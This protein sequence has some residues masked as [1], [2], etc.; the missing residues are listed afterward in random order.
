MGLIVGNSAAKDILH[1]LLAF[2]H[3]DPL[4]W[5]RYIVRRGYRVDL[6]TTRPLGFI[7]KQ[8]HKSTWLCDEPRQR[9]VV[10]KPHGSQSLRCGQAPQANGNG[11]APCRRIAVRVIFALEHHCAFL[12]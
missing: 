11:T 6:L 4:L 1:T 2:E 12:R 8:I 5:I 3:L 9:W 10:I 7:I